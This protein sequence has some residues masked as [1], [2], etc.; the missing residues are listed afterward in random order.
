MDYKLYVEQYLNGN[1]CCM[2]NDL[3]IS[4]KKIRWEKRRSLRI[5][6]TII[7]LISAC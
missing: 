7:T 6:V 3:K 5:C 2:F 4:K 1:S